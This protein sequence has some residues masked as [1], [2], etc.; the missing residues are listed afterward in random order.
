L[1]E[2]VVLSHDDINKDDNVPPEVETPQDLHV[3]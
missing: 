2:A 1:T 3:V